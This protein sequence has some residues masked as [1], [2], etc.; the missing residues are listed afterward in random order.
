MVPFSLFVNG[1]EIQIRQQI[2][3][4]ACG[5]GIMLLSSSSDNS[6]ANLLI[7]IPPHAL[8]VLEY[9]DKKEIIDV[10]DIKSRIE[11]IQEIVEIPIIDDEIEES[12][13]INRPF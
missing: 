1:V 11:S 6:P 5:G 10:I 8:C 3:I 9:K 2:K 7:T 13:R 4:I 12:E